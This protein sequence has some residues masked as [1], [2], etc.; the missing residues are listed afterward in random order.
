LGE[1]EEAIKKRGLGGKA[2]QIEKI[3][4]GHSM[5]TVRHQGSVGG[6]ID[7]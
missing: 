2:S 7:P 4:P 5:G 6:G 3:L 1:G